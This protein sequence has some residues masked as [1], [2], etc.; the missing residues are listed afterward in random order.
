VTSDAWL[1]NRGPLAAV[2][3]LLPGPPAFLG[4]PSDD[5]VRVRWSGLDVYLDIE[6]ARLL[7]GWPDLAGAPV[8]DAR[9]FATGLLE[10]GLARL[11]SVPIEASSK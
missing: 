3:V 8:A 1:Q 10:S 7:A 5:E 9:R 2:R 11:D 6:E 4:E